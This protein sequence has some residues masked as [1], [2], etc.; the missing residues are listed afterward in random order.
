MIS[1]LCG[2][3]LD[4][5]NRLARVIWDRLRWTEAD[6]EIFPGKRQGALHFNSRPNKQ[7]CSAKSLRFHIGAN[8]KRLC[9]HA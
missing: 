3:A 8:A 6:F 1:H 5:P 9:K 4:H 7:G 2:G